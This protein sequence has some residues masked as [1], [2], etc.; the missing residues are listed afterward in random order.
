MESNSLAWCYSLNQR[1]IFDLFRLNWQCFTAYS[2]LSSILLPKHTFLPFA[3]LQPRIFISG[4]L[5]MIDRPGAITYT[6]N[7]GWL[8]EKLPKVKE[9]LPISHEDNW[10]FFLLFFWH[11]KGDLGLKQCYLPSSLGPQWWESSTPSTPKLVSMSFSGKH[12]VTGGGSWMTYALI[13]DCS[14]NP[15]ALILKQD[16]WHMLTKLFNGLGIGDNITV[17]VWRRNWINRWGNFEHMWR[18]T[19]IPFPSNSSSWSS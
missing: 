10:V 11:K 4:F 15:E 14:E 3:Q 6:T 16:I 7:N 12:R 17:M 19:L 1:P 18:L 8:S 13:D 9:P 2:V 5:K